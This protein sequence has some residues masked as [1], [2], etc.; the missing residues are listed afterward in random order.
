MRRSVS[1]LAVLSKIDDWVLAVCIHRYALHICRTLTYF[2]SLLATYSESSTPH[3][4]KPRRKKIG[5]KISWTDNRTAAGPAWLIPDFRRTLRLT[6]NVFRLLSSSK[7]FQDTFKFSLE[8]RTPPQSQTN[9]TIKTGWVAVACKRAHVTR[10]NICFA[11]RFILNTYWCCS[12]NS[13][14]GCPCSCLDVILVGDSFLF[15]LVLIL[16]ASSTCEGEAATKGA[17]KFWKFGN[18]RYTERFGSTTSLRFAIDAGPKLTF[19]NRYCFCL[20]KVQE[21]DGCLPSQPWCSQRCWSDAWRRDLI[22]CSLVVV[23]HFRISRLCIQARPRYPQQIL[24]LPK[25][26]LLLWMVESFPKRSTW[27]KLCQ[28][29]HP[30][31]RHL[32]RMEQ[33][34]QAWRVDQTSLLV[35]PEGGRFMI[36]C[37]PNV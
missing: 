18:V 1:G 24:L 5:S 19:A 15:L 14:G 11:L 36:L 12:P 16:F 22:L 9:Q 30:Q 32:P 29:R 31:P 20:P 28:A 37:R 6:G 27:T 8:A 33:R 3:R 2:S 13:C 23:S 25:A 35:V 10:Y 26:E 7:F 4:R 21:H 34:W 17:Q